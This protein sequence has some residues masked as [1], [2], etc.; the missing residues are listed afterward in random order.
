[1]CDLLG[2]R[3]SVS[4]FSFAVVIL[5]QTPLHHQ[6]ATINNAPEQ[7]HQTATTFTP[8]NPTSQASPRLPFSNDAQQRPSIAADF[9]PPSPSSS[10]PTS[11][12]NRGGLLTACAFLYGRIANFP[13][14]SDQGRFTPP[15]PPSN[16]QAWLRP[17]GD[18]DPKIT[19]PAPPSVYKGTYTGGFESG[20]FS[21]SLLESRRGVSEGSLRLCE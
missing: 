20:L 4:R 13:R 2:L 10:R 12:Q 21:F 11:A 5:D 3:S 7:L 9:S 6:I 16:G 15:F 1:M 17:R 18:F 14:N 19:I 8:T